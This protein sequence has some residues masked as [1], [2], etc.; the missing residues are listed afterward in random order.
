MQ[1]RVLHLAITRLF[2]VL[3]EA[4]NRVSP[5]TRST[6]PSIPWRDAID[7]RNVLIHAY[8]TVDLHIV[9]GTAEHDIPKLVLELERA[10][11]DRAG[12]SS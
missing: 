9:W 4:A 5:E 8:D 12:D 10:I 11:A 3:G 7:L 6:F 1:D 2:E